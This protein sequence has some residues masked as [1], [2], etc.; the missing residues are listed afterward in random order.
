MIIRGLTT[1]DECRQVAALEM[2]VWGYTDAEDVVPPPVLIVS[3]KRG[4]ILLGAFDDHDALQGFVFLLLTFLRRELLKRRGNR[5]IDAE[6]E[7]LILLRS[8]A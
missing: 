4:G 6:I 5:S 7:N 3:I 1:I 8:K 2:D